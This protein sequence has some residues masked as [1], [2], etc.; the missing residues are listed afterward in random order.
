MA[1]VTFRDFAAAIMQGNVEAAGGV[2]QQL[3]ALDADGARAAALH[4]QAQAA[5]GGPA[6]MGKAMGLRSAVAS[7]T[8]EDIA[9]LLTDCFGLADPQRAAAVDALRP[10]KPA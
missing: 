6:F 5:S 9:A 2:L 4:F 3:L 7:G 8:R 1:E 10:A